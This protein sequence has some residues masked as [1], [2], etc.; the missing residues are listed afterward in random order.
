[1][2]TI[3]FDIQDLDDAERTR[4]ELKKQISSLNEN[5][6]KT[7]S[8]LSVALDIQNLK[9]SPKPEERALGELASEIAQI[10]SMLVNNLRYLRRVSPLD[11]WINDWRQSL[12]P[13]AEFSKSSSANDRKELIAH[14]LKLLARASPESPSAPLSPHSEEKTEV[15]ADP[16]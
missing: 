15:P 13:V 4:E 2:R 8:P 3:H 16:D 7:E 5:P 12:L 10:K 9:G 1:M 14:L 11:P 6:D